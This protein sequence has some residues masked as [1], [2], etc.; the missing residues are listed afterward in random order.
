MFSV[1][2]ASNEVGSQKSQFQLFL[3]SVQ[4]I[5]PD[6]SIRDILQQYPTPQMVMIGSESTGKS[7]TLE[8]LTKKEIFPTNQKTCTRCPIKVVMIPTADGQPPSTT[9]TFRKA[10]TVVNDLNHL[11]QQIEMLFDMIGKESA[12][13]YCD[14][15][16][17]ITFYEEDAVRIDL[18]DLPGIVSY[19]PAARDFTT[20][21]CLRYIRDPNSLIICVAPATHPRLNSYEPI[22][23]LLENAAQDRTIVTLTMPDKLRPEDYNSQL[24]ERVRMLAEEFNGTKF[25]ACCAVVNRA[26]PAIALIEQPNLERAWFEAN[27]LQDQSSANRLA[28][29]P[30]LGIESLLTVAKK[31]YDQFLKDKWVPGTIV[32]IDEDI[33]RIQQKIDAIGPLVTEEFLIKLRESTSQNE[34]HQAFVACYQCLRIAEAAGSVAGGSQAAHN[35]FG[36]TPV[37]SAPVANGGRFGGGFGGFSSPPLYPATN[38]SSPKHVLGVAF[39]V[40]DIITQRYVT[41]LSDLMLSRIE[42]LDVA[43][44]LAKCPTNKL[45]LS[46]FTAFW[47]IVKHT[48]CETVKNFI[49]KGLLILQPVLLQ[50]VM[51]GCVSA[52]L[53][54][55]GHDLVQECMPTFLARCLAQVTKENMVEDWAIMCQREALQQQSERLQ[56][57]KDA[58]LQRGGRRAAG[59]DS[60]STGK[61]DRR[62]VAVGQK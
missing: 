20:A 19:P 24:R 17:M 52:S 9:V 13:G 10:D 55:D 53:A 5:Y 51:K 42:A 37:S 35:V 34:M 22:A 4:A 25:L 11:K 46:R 43:A 18:V 58:L 1:L 23:R 26:S 39:T 7:A 61:S 57:V 32:K 62:K 8:N 50:Q 54:I 6:K 40:A 29:A 59:S 36:S 2:K 60:T 21:M 45:L 27:I 38:T 41:I 33:V 3:D 47:E 44:V 56:V 14:D 49:A 28:L 31:Q 12:S 15:E 16:I 48:M 30:R